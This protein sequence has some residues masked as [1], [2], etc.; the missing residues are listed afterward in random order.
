MHCV[1][2]HLYIAIYVLS[3]HKIVNYP[4]TCTLL[5]VSAINRHP[6]GGVNWMKYTYILIYMF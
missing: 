4:E 5:H 6:Q 1:F 2:N 3:L